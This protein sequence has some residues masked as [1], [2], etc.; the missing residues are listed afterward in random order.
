MRQGMSVLVA[1]SALAALLAAAP[2]PAIT[3][4]AYAACEPGDKVDRS[5]ADDARRKIEKAGYRKVSELKKSCANFWHGKALK[6]GAETR[7]VLSPLGEVHP[8]GE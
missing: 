2:L 6:D 7:V 3:G 4:T 8:E 1:A 5:T